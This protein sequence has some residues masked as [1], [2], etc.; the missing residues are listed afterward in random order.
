MESNPTDVSDHRDNTVER[1]RE[2]DPAT[3]RALVDQY[4]PRL[5]GVARS[6]A[7]DLDHAHDLLQ[8]SWVR[9]YEKR[10]QYSGSGSLAGWLYSVTRSVC[11]A[12]ARKSV[13]QTVIADTIA[14]T[15]TAD[16]E[17]EQRELRA[18]LLEAVFALPEREREIV[19]A[20]LIDGLSTKETANA[21]GC[22]EGT[23]K[24]GLHHAV[25]KLRPALEVWRDEVVSRS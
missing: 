15:E 13:P 2:G 3:F 5:L 7:R 9:V 22:A 8:A 17:A 24:A 12:D 25:A 21:L 10:H 20:R 6:F 1:F 18:A 4:S 16:R 11:L 23:V 19:I 14:G